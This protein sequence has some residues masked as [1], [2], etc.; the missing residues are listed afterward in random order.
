MLLLLFDV[1]S[2][3]CFIF[4]FFPSVCSDHAVHCFLYCVKEG[5]QARVPRRYLAPLTIIVLPLLSR[6]GPMQSGLT[7]FSGKPTSSLS[8]KKKK[9]LCF[10][11]NGHV[12]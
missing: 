8:K 12:K 10:S 11:K 6:K 9:T 5:A 3:G 7:V 2:E 1:H 4:L